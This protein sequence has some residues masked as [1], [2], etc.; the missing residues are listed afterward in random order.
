MSFCGCWW[1]EQEIS[2]R[3]VTGNYTQIWNEIYLRKHVRT[4]LGAR[5]VN[6]LGNH[7]TGDVKVE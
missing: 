1:K 3:N 2:L 6:F 7:R 5:K 4:C